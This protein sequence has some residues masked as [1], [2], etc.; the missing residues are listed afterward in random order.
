MQLRL[1][2]QLT[3]PPVNEVKT[4]DGGLDSTVLI[5]LA[6]AVVVLAVLLLI[7]RQLFRKPK[8]TLPTAEAKVLAG[9][10]A[11]APLVAPK[12]VLPASEAEVARLAEVEAARKQA[13]EARRQQ[14]ALA[15]E[16]KGADDK[17]KAEVAEKL[18]ALKA[19]EE[20][21]KKQAYQAQ[22]GAD[23]EEKKRHEAER[24]ESKRQAAGLAEQA[25]LAELAAREAA[26]AAEK[27]RIDAQAGQT[28]FAGLQKTKNEGFMSGL[29]R[30]FG[31][32]PK[33]IDESVLAELEEVLFT[34]DIGVKTAQGLVTLARDKAKK[35]ERKRW[36]HR[37]PETH[38]R[39]TSIEA[40]K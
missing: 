26:A 7:L 16:A 22:K 23:A 28:L 17:T 40:G 29:N 31:G 12:V 6:V 20:I 30:L 3:V 37:Q 39:V 38:I 27:I 10:T 8:A 35:N 34:A 13:E 32:A 24:E 2:A 4:G 21:A 5:I 15:A 1:L 9:E 14:L 11:T 25:R 19:Q 36:G 18:Q 33:A